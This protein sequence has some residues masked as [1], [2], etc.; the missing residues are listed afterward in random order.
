MLDQFLRRTIAQI[1]CWTVL[2]Q[3]GI[4]W[5][6][7][8]PVSPPDPPGFATARALA[9]DVRPL[10]AAGEVS[11]VPA[12]NL[13]S[14]PAPPLDPRPSAVFAPLGSGLERVYAY[15]ACD[16]NDPWKLYDPADPAGSDLTAVSETQG[17]WLDATAAALLPSPGEPP[18]SSVIHLCTGW[19]LVGFPASQPRP[20]ASALASIAGKFTRVY[21]YEAD[22]AAD[23]WEVYDVGV[24]AWANDLKSLRPG[25]GYWILATQEADL[26]ITDDRTALGVDVASPRDGAVVTSPTAVVGTVTGAALTS[27]TLEVRAQGDTA[28]TEIGSGTDP[29]SGAV[30]GTLDPT[31]LLNGLY[32]IRLQATDAGGQSESIS[33]FVT[34]EGGLKIG[35]LT[36]PF[37]DLELSLVGLPVQ[38]VRTYDSRD[39]RPGDFGVGWRLSFSEVSLRETAPAGQFWQGLTSGGPFP[40][41]CIRSRAAHV[42][43]VTLPGGEVLRFAPVVAPECQPLV[44]QSAVTISY[45]P[46]SGTQGTLVPLDQGTS[47][48]VVGS[49]PGDIQL[50]EQESAELF[51]PSRFRLTLPDGR[52]L[53]LVKDQGLESI[54]D[55][56]GNAV[57]F[58]ANSISHSSGVAVNVERDSQGRVARITDPAGGALDYTYDAADDLVRVR[59]QAGLETTFTYLPGHYLDTITDPQGNKILAAQYAVDKRLIGQCSPAATGTAANCVQ[60]THD[61]GQG[62]EVRTDPT[63]RS[64]TYTY[65][66]RGNV[67]SVADGLGQTTRFEY[68]AQGSLTKATDPVGAVTRATYDGTGNLLTRT[69]PHEPSES[70]ADFTTTYTYNGA[71][72][73]SAIIEPTGARTVLAYDAAGHLTEVRDGSGRLQS[74]FTYDSRGALTSEGDPFGASTYAD[75]TSFNE[76]RTITGPP[77]ETITAEYNALGKITAMTEGSRTST[78]QYDPRGRRTRA[79]FG[80]GQAVDFTYGTGD[81]WRSTSSPTTGLIRRDLYPDGHLKGWTLSAGRQIGYQYD[82]AGR[83]TE[84]TDAAGRVARQ[85]YDGAGRTAS[86]TAPNGGVTRYVYDAAGR[87]TT[88]TD[89]LGHHQDNEYTVDGRPRRWTDENG[90]SW[91]FAYGLKRVEQTDPLARTAR[92]D[93]SDEG[94]PLRRTNPD[95]STTELTYLDTSPVTEREA[96][97]T[98]AKDEAGRTRRFA[99]NTAGQLVSATDLAGTAITYEYDG[100]RLRDAKGPGGE[101][102]FTLDYDSRDNVKK[103]AWADGA[104]AE[105]DY[106]ANNRPSALRRSSGLTVTQTYDAANRPASRTSSLGDTTTLTWTAGDQIETVTDAR[107]VTHREYDALG[108]LAAETAPDGSRVEIER[109]LRGQVTAVRSRAGAAAPIYE[110]RYEHDPA[111]NLTKV[112]DPLGGVTT[113][114]VDDANRPVRR[115]LPN[116][117]VTLWEYDLRDRVRS[118]THRNAAG[119]ILASASY[120]R[121]PSGEPTKVTREDGSSAIYEYDAALRLSAEKHYDPAGGL[122]ETVAYTYDALGNRTSRSDAAGASTWTYGP[123]SRLTAVTGPA[124]SAT[125]GYDGDG[126][127]VSI[128]R[129]GSAVQ[130]AYDSRDLIASWTDQTTGA[131]VTYL[132]DGLGR[133]VG[134][135]SGTAARR[136]VVAPAAGEGLDAPQLLLDGAG[137]LQAGYVYTPGGP[138]LRFGPDGPVYYLTDGLG[139]VLA[140]ADTAGSAAARFTYDAFGAVRSAAGPQAA[141]PGAL[142]GDFRFQG[143]WLEDT[144]GLYHLPAR[145][146]DPAT[147]RFLTRDPASPDPLVPESLHPYAFAN[148]NPQLYRDPTGMFTIIEVNISKTVEGNLQNMKTIAINYLKQRVKEEVKKAITKI[149]INQLKQ[150]IPFDPGSFTTEIINEAIGGEEGL[151]AGI[152]FGRYVQG[153]VCDLLGPAKGKLWFEAAVEEATG[154]PVSNGFNCQEDLGFGEIKAGT[155]RPDLLIRDTEPVKA[156]GRDTYM[157][158]EFKLSLMTFIRAYLDPGY[159]KGQ[160]Q[161]IS[162]H[163]LNYQTVEVA[164]FVALFK[165]GYQEAQLLD[166]A[167]SGKI[168]IIAI[169]FE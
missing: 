143:A 55:R 10:A 41:Y 123:G 168:G 166:I 68:D 86:V 85:T 113:F 111:G 51:N 163:V 125:Y 102:L 84:S 103:T 78:F 82:A 132:H 81:D 63:G 162:N 120:E 91:T 36:L 57:T 20:V 76:P 21:G 47:A 127:T 129:G 62:K 131:A 32:E 16:V 109:D 42:V 17:L 160:W 157:T 142:G 8:V 18:L 19:N 134:A 13:V 69:A 15:D 11:L 3:T 38:V 153:I 161:A 74:S 12:W 92:I 22:D 155:R 34:L 89:P 112:T 25:H 48:A 145:D 45:Q 130:L 150:M 128:D 29:V 93:L 137:S 114:E 88:Q 140:L 73:L 90:K 97:P 151:A 44:P 65:D 40:N 138:L 115:T 70:D 75:L 147:G 39:K 101:T 133:R 83:L 60:L 149:L 28:W 24:P 27:W 6:D 67:T 52:K 116:G 94:L 107:G 87:V 156:N 56:D 33:A 9:A 30:L 53:V 46:L 105:T 159:N 136:F 72:K 164:L 2:L 43:A 54:E 135:T 96:F 110:T 59:D 37:L 169:T 31:L 1:F 104:W 23:A 167:R 61:L 95:G 35:N 99:Y 139:S 117:V 124:G 7:G 77:G 64:T 118:V 5:A 80:D 106:G 165:K 146:Y 152:Q 79:D 148:G 4:A 26:T 71:G 14:L 108:G 50:W 158:A 126:R 66:S 154:K 119:Q 122:L 58:T 121:S 98:S 141:A 144:T 100:R 49:F